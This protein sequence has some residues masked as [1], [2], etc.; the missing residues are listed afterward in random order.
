MQLVKPSQSSFCYLMFTIQDLEL[1]KSMACDDH[2]DESSLLKFIKFALKPTHKNVPLNGNV[3]SL[4][5]CLDISHCENEFDTNKST[6]ELILGFLSLKSLI[7]LYP[8][9]FFS[10]L[11]LKV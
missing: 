11:F 8:R 3:A 4:L 9:M 7:C 10:F 1:Q 2:M 5:T 6:L